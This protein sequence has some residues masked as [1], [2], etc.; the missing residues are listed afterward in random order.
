MKLKTAENFIFLYKKEGDRDGEDDDDDNN[1]D[2]NDDDNDDD[3]EDGSNV[4]SDDGSDDVVLIRPITNAEEE[5]TTQPSC[6]GP[7]RPSRRRRGQRLSSRRGSIPAR[8][9][10]AAAAP[11]SVRPAAAAAAAAP[12]SVRAAACMPPSVPTCS[13]GRDR[14]FRPYSDG[15]EYD[16]LPSPAHPVPTDE[17]GYYSSPVVTPFAMRVMGRATP[18]PPYSPLSDSEG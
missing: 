11:G 3:G 4:S 18:P 13:E 15:A 12:G 1:D 6:A 7:T 8:A 10:T 9:A 5:D 14:N 2:G 16:V 17:S